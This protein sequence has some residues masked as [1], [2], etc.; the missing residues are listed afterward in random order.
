MT[1]HTNISDKNWTINYL[2]DNSYK[3]LIDKNEY[4]TFSRAWREIFSNSFSYNN[5]AVFNSLLINDSLQ[6][7]FSSI[8]NPTTTTIVDP[9]SYDVFTEDITNLISV[10]KPFTFKDSLHKERSLMLIDESFSE[11]FDD[12]LYKNKYDLICLQVRNDS[13]LLPETIEK[14]YMLLNDYGFLFIEINS[15]TILEPISKT[16]LD[17]YFTL[18]ENKVRTPISKD[19]HQFLMYRKI[20]GLV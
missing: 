16:T 6:L 8:V 7:I 17:H 14:Y 10:R 4:T 5:S 15:K 12:C 18:L 13:E 3:K 11:A 19:T 2:S 1:I 20:K 9:L